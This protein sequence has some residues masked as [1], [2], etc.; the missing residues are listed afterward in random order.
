[1]TQI[2][3]QKGG[4]SGGGSSSSVESPDNLRSIQ[5]ARLLDLI[6]EGEVEGLATGDLRSVYLNKT[7]IMNEDG[8]S[9]FTGVTFAFRSGSQNQAYIDG[10]PDAESEKSVGVQVNK[11]SPV[12]RGL[13]GASFDA[14]RVTI[15][16]PQLYKTNTKTGNTSGSS[17]E[18]KISL[19]S[20]GGSYVD[21]QTDKIKGKTTTRYQKSYLI[22]LTGSAPWNIKVTRITDDSSTAY[23]QNDL[24]FDSFTEINHAKLRYPN[25]VLAGSIIDAQQFSAVPTRGYDMK[26][27]QIQIPSNATVREDGSLT[28][29]G[30][31]DGTF[32]VAWSSNPA[33]VFY[34]MIV[35]S[36]YGLGDFVDAAQIDKWQLYA[37]GRYCDELVPDGFGGQEPRFSCNLYI[38]EQREA[39]T[40]IQDLASIF[41]GIAYW[42]NAQ[43]TASQDAPS[44]PVSLYTN[45]NVIDGVF[46]YEGT[47]QK[48]RHTTVLVNWN[49]PADFYAARPEFVEDPAG[50]A[51]YGVK[52]KSVVATGCTSRGQAHRV[53]KWILY[54]EIE[55]TETVRF[56]T[57]L[58]GSNL[59]PNNI[60][61]VHDRD[62]VG[63]RLAG[64]IVTAT[65]TQI[66][67][68]S[69]FTTTAGGTYTMNIMMPDGTIGSGTIS[70]V[71][72]NVVTL[73][74][75]LSAIPNP[76]A[77]WMVMSTTIEPQLFRVLSAVPN[78]E[79]IDIVALTYNADK[80]LAIENNVILAER[81]ISSLN[82]IPNAPE[83]IQISE[84]LYQSAAS[85]Q[86]LVRFSW[87]QVP[88]AESYNLTYSVGDNN[89][90][91]VQGVRSQIFEIKDAS[92]GLY[93]VNIQAVSALGRVSSFGTAQKTVYGKTARPAD[94]QNFSMVGVA[95]GVA[96]LVW[97]KAVDLDVIVGGYVR[98]RHTPE[99]VAPSWSSAVDIGPAL[100]GTATSASLPHIDGTYL[101]K[102]IDSSDNS[103]LT[104]ATVQTKTAS[105]IAMNV[106]ATINESGFTG[107]KTNTFYPTP[108]G[109]LGL[110]ADGLFSAIPLVSA[111]G[112]IFGYGAV[113][114]SGTYEFANYFDLGDVYVSRVT[115]TIDA[116][117]YDQ[118]DIVGS[119]LDNI[120]EWESFLGDIADDTNARLYISTTNDNPAGSPT[121]SSWRPFFVGQYEARAYKFMLELTSN[122][123]TH[124]IDITGLSV[125]IDMPDRTEAERNLTTTTSPVSVTFPVAFKVAPAIGITANNLSSGDYFVISGQS[126]TGFT[127]EFKNSAGASVARNFDYIA[128]GYG[129][130]S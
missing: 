64:R 7:P 114:N 8:S 113:Y 28:Y 27:L 70:S 95:N 71:V 78:E 29:T 6:C 51:L 69:G 93:D 103:S 58:D 106:V 54:S 23:V 26:L 22:P 80:Y 50:I 72:G 20:N 128:K 53:G 3:G 117:G 10:F 116:V 12:V 97:D 91:T 59:R 90:V 74:G 60:I 14:V 25:S 89:P 87:D 121:W 61:K 19:Q 63:L 86:T 77:I 107:A 125:T 45:A 24:Y 102:F 62:R 88:N 47:S 15:G 75:P 33:W 108:L 94:V 98:I 42:S 76:D 16:I 122:I 44:D 17:V 65:A 2:K 1:M 21:V 104:E 79:S 101:A 82:V 100:S 52:S 112:S 119:R 67:V 126:A 99:T 11:D 18:F 81:P 129:Y 48:A 4:K 35:N 13:S 73:T 68:D 84:E 92:T 56:K 32:Q 46:T 111:V 5:Y 127:I 123:S 130:S 124:N 39:Y 40:V 43:I 38:Q 30:S 57:G 34:D 118:L 110:M 120:S 41:R 85:V 109:G 49:D 31:W 83:N 55:E 36:R 115:A 37:I 96:E 9:N 105:L 66:T